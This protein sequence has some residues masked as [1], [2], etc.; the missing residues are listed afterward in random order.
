[1]S[2]YVGSRASCLI[3]TAKA[4]SIALAVA[5]LLGE[6]HDRYHG[7]AVWPYIDLTPFVDLRIRHDPERSRAEVIRYVEEIS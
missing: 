3:A 1:M 4:L 2:C 6:F 5:P 7:P